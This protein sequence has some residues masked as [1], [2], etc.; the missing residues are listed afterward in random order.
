MRK[1][2][3]RETDADVVTIWL[4]NF[5]TGDLVSCV[6]VCVCAAASASAAAKVSERAHTHTHGSKNE[7]GEK[8]LCGGLIINTHIYR[9]GRSD[10]FNP[11]PAKAVMP[12]HPV[13]GRLRSR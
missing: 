9:F 12:Q 3:V 1:R 2:V 4:V 6:C 13:P 11:F 8:R 7:L 5:R 10:Q